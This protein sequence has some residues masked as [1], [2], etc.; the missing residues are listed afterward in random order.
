V[1]RCRRLPP[2]SFF[3]RW[4]AQQDEGMRALVTQLVDSGQVRNTHVA[5]DARKAWQALSSEG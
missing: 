2:Q 1:P 5:A 4:W 3:M